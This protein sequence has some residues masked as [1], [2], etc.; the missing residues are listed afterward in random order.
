MHC[1]AP[2]PTLPSMFQTAREPG[3]YSVELTID[4][5]HIGGEWRLAGG[6]IL[7]FFRKV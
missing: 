7:F 4:S 1:T 2:R 6:L 3:F 5:I